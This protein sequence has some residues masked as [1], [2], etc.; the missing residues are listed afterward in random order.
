[1]K[2]IGWMLLAALVLQSAPAIGQTSPG[3]GAQ[4]DAQSTKLLKTI[5]KEAQADSVDYD[6]LNAANRA[7]RVYLQKAL[8]SRDAMS[9]PLKKASDA[10]LEVFTSSDNKVKFCSWDT[11]TGGT[12]HIFTSLVAYDAGNGQIKCKI[13]NETT[14]LEDGGS[15]GSMFEALHTVKTKDGRAVYVVQD[16]A[17]LSGM[18]HERG[19]KAYVIAN[20]KLT[21]FPL[22][23]TP[24]KALDSISFGFGEYSDRAQFELSADKQTLK[25]PIVLEDKSGVS[26]GKLTGK[27]L[28]YRF[29][30]NRFVFQK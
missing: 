16:L 13:M 6:K 21:G 14:T 8:L 11:L 1:M 20:G 18:V 9:N 10:G 23:Q 12:M 22:F 15:P 4:V 19:I 25:V 26:G 3:T 2:L 7:L 27:Y 17:I 30:G 28:T 5:S 24:K 29:D